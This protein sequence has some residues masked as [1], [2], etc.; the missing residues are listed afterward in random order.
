[1]GLTDDEIAKLDA[2]GVPSDQQVW[3]RYFFSHFGAPPGERHA[4]RDALLAAGFS[5]V[6]AD[7]EGSDP[8][9]L[10]YWSHTIRFADRDPLREADRRAAVIADEHG[11]RYDAWEVARN[12]TTGEL[13]PVE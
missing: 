7:T 8:Y 6:G 1:M 4:F 10:H 5:N 12:S 3:T 11:V 2:E 9:Y 13:R